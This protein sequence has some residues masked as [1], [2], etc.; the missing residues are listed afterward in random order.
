MKS[1]QHPSKDTVMWHDVLMKK[2]SMQG[3]SSD[4]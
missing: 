2:F 3:A 1:S 4:V